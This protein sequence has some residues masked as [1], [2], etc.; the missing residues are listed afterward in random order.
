V[1][2]KR[3]VI[4]RIMPMKAAFV[5]SQFSKDL[6]GHD[7]QFDQQRNFI[8][9]RPGSDYAAASITERDVLDMD[10]VGTA[11][12]YF[13]LRYGIRAMAEY[14][15]TVIDSGAYSNNGFV[16]TEPVAVPFRAATAGTP[17]AVYNTG[18]VTAAGLF[19][20]AVIPFRVVRF[21]QR[22]LLD[23]S[24]VSGVKTI[25]AGTAAAPNTVTAG[26]STTLL[27]FT[28]ALS[29]ASLISAV[30]GSYTQLTQLCN[31]LPYGQRV[32][33]VGD[34]L[35][36]SIPV[37]MPSVQLGCGI[38]NNTVDTLMT[39]TTVIDR[40]VRGGS[41]STA[42]LGDS[43]YIAGGGGPLIR[44]NGSR[45]SAAG[46]APAAS[47]KRAQNTIPGMTLSLTGTGITGTYNYRVL[48]RIYQ[49]NG[50]YIDGEAFSLGS[51]TPANQ[52]VVVNLVTARRRAQVF[53]ARAGGTGGQFGGQPDSSVGPDGVQR[54]PAPFYSASD[55]RQASYDAVTGA[56]L[57]TVAGFPG[58]VAELR[59]GDPLFIYNSAGTLYHKTYVQ[60]VLPDGSVVP[61][62]TSIFDANDPTNIICSG[63]VLVVLRTLSGADNTTYYER[64]EIPIGVSSLTD[65][66]SDASLLAQLQYT[67]TAYLRSP[68][69]LATSA[70]TVHQTRVVIGAAPN[71]LSGTSNLFNNLCWSEPNTEHFPPENS[72]E[73]PCKYIS[74]L[75]SVN[76][77]LYAFTDAGIFTFSGAL[78]DPTT[79][80]MSQLGTVLVAASGSTAVAAGGMI[81]FLTKD[82]R[83]GMLSGAEAQT[84]LGLL[85]LDKYSLAYATGV[86]SPTDQKT[87]FFCP[88]KDSYVL[89]GADSGPASDAT[90]EG[91]RFP[92]LFATGNQVGDCLVFDE[93]TGSVFM[94]TGV[95]GIGGACF[96]DGKVWFANRDSQ[97]VSQVSYFDAAA[98]SDRGNAVS[99][100]V[101]AP[102]EDDDTP[103]LDKQFG[104][105][106]LYAPEAAR[107]FTLGVGLAKDWNSQRY[108]QSFTY[109]FG[110]GKGYGE[111][112]YGT[113][114]YG[115]PSVPDK[116]L[117]LNNIKAKAVQLS[118]THADITETPSISGWSLEYSETSREGR[119]D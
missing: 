13:A 103:H 38:V 14:R 10:N 5:D 9:R 51:V 59:A 7:W 22:T 92:R 98:T 112:D 74:S 62:N 87:Y 91:Q 104:K 57:L 83:V 109:P 11:T 77:V 53:S 34:Y 106:S 36:V 47:L 66:M 107:E 105:L 49:P 40:S 95:S 85:Q 21:S 117:N 68:P 86:Y 65:A 30:Y 80:T 90:T 108:T 12:N 48:H 18:E 81:R 61:R 43:L 46:A 58:M 37:R 1:A 70:V 101:I 24:S 2:Q 56:C 27:T 99:M 25:K 15:R 79:F 115:G 50:S 75:V 82:G 72:V 63:D 42:Q 96:F 118:F 55:Y 3:N 119:E 76:D 93:G 64:A 54:I 8:V 69:P 39:G 78:I 84:V 4:T 116:V 113:D 67:D 73:L 94:Y 23:V 97:L 111:A 26:E 71:G 29:A 20:W 17:E 44:Y 102:F 100:Q 60:T 88:Y 52:S 32:F 45:F 31:L 33:E 41:L 114:A 6:A 28:N 19:V 35:E 16:T 110:V 89:T